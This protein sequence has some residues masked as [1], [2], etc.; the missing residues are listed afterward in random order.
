LYETCAVGNPAEDVGNTNRA[1]K[2]TD[3][4]TTFFVGLKNNNFPGCQT[5]NS[6]YECTKY[7]DPQISRVPL[8]SDTGKIL[9]AEPGTNTVVV[10][11]E[12]G[13][14]HAN[15]QSATD[16]DGTVVSM[17]TSAKELR[18]NGMAMGYSLP[19]ANHE[20]KE[21][22]MDVREPVKKVKL[23]GKAFAVMLPQAHTVYM[24]VGKDTHPHEDAMTALK[25]AKEEGGKIRI[26]DYVWVTG[27]NVVS[28]SICNIVS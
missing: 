16:N 17:I 10:N 23:E 24:G 13:V 9:T 27:A 25:R 8:N 1:L 18:K 4:S 22:G 28:P 11:A 15:Q 19:Y 3:S 6:H 21:L 2:V 20:D 7:S 14:I 26:G 12:D 5:M